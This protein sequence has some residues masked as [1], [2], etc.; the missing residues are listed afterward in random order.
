[1]KLILCISALLLYVGNYWICEWVYPDNLQAWWELRG[2]L[3]AAIFLLGLVAANLNTTGATRF[4]MNIAIGLVGADLIDRLFFDVTTYQWKD[5]LTL[6]L[7][8]STSF[9]AWRYKS[10]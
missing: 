9:Y 10:N 5:L 1:M 3:Y 8:L 6:I 7:T 2:V 4:I